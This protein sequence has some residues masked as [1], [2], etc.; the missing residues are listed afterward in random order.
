MAGGAFLEDLIGVNADNMAQE[1]NNYYLRTLHSQLSSSFNF[2][3]KNPNMLK[4]RL[5]IYTAMK[6]V[7]DSSWKKLKNETKL[8][9]CR[10]EVEQNN[11]EADYDLVR[12]I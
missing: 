9:I 1:N 12:K 4:N 7:N 11:R 10:E 2:I 5:T 3:D 6:P 8:K